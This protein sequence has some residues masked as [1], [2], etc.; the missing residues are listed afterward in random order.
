MIV[1]ALALTFTL[2]SFAAAAGAVALIAYR[3]RWL[4]I[5]AP[6]RPLDL[7]DAAALSAVSFAFFMIARV[8]MAV[9]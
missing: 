4:W 9:A 5:D 6:R 1:F 2:F 3:L 7:S 8:A